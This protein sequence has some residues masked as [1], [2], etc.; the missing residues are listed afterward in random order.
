MTQPDGM[1][2]LAPKP[3]IPWR[4]LL[5]GA[6]QAVAL[7]LLVGLAQAGVLPAGAAALVAG[8]TLVLLLVPLMVL[9]GLQ[10][11]AP[12]AL[13]VWCALATV[14]LGGL[15]AWD[16]LRLYMPLA[17]A[18]K[19]GPVWA[20]LPSPGIVMAGVV[21]AVIGQLTV[22]VWAQT[23]RFF[24]P[25]A[26]YFVRARR[27]WIE[28]FLSGAFAG[29]CWLILMM[30]ARLLGF[31]A[32]SGL[33][34]IILKPAVAVPV[35]TFGASLGLIL[36]RPRAMAIGEAGTGLLSQLAWL[37]PL[38]CL[39]AIAFLVS[40]TI[41]G[42]D[43]VWR[44]APPSAVMLAMAAG[45]IALINLLWQSGSHRDM[46]RPVLRHAATLA[47]FLLVPIVAIAVYAL[48]VRVEAY[49]FSVRRVIAGAALAVA[50]VFA[51]GYALAAWSGLRHGRWLVG[52]GTANVAGTLV[53][54]G[55]LL[56]VCSPLADPARIAVASQLARLK[57]GRISAEQFDFTY[58]ASQGA[59][60]GH[61]ALQ[62]LAEDTVGPQAALIR[63]RARK[64][65]Q[66]TQGQVALLT[67]AQRAAQLRVYPEYYALPAGIARKVW[68][69]AQGVPPCLVETG[70]FCDVF[71]AELTGHPPDQLIL[72][73]G[74]PQ[75]WQ[76]AVVGM[77]PSS[78]WQVIG[79]FGGLCHSTVAALRA[80]LY[81]V[82][83]PVIT[84]RTLEVDGLD[85]NVA[86]VLGPSTSCARRAPKQ[87]RSGGRSHP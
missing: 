8:L 10:D 13:W 30:T 23:E 47:A 1:K 44:N 3:E 11:V 62:A 51:V 58:L 53:L 86:P 9:E 66:D 57:S 63:A 19:N 80:G 74:G 59:G 81:A 38:A 12:G 78:G 68:R 76:T 18:V 43:G 55:V 70:Q 27:L 83:A 26:V 48:T 25:Y 31:G 64:V 22:G 71:P 16:R 49:G 17:L 82:V 33:G 35:S 6:G 2:G 77:V 21:L 54:A 79:T 32:L 34:R 5:I 84:Y 73:W 39:A 67:P 46:P 42:F 28:A 45:L 4:K 15:G 24:A 29:A 56:L 7:A 14:I 69:P 41:S 36:G 37:L 60:F 75:V 85:L 52:L 65:L 20:F 50:A 87:S 40:V 61:R 72:V